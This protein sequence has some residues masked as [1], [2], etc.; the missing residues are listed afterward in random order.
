V[1]A[2]HIRSFGLCISRRK[3]KRQVSS[4]PSTLNLTLPFEIQVSEHIER[5]VNLLQGDEVTGEV[6]GGD[7]DDD[8]DNDGRIEEI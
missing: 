2:V 1:R 6:N 5:L 3:T 4:T 7:E 8:D